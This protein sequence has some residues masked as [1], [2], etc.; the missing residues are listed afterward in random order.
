[1]ARLEGGSRRAERIDVR[2]RGSHIDRLVQTREMVKN[3]RH[4][5]ETRGSRKGSKSLRI[6]QQCSVERRALAAGLQGADSASEMIA[7]VRHPTLHT[8][9]RPAALADLDALVALEYRV[10]TCDRISRRSFRRFLA[11]PSAA[12]IAA[13]DHGGLAG[14]A[15]VL[16]RAGSPVARLY[17]IAVATE[18]AGRGIGSALLAA[19]EDAAQRHGA[20]AMRL[21]VNEH[22]AAAISRYRKAD[23]RLFARRTAY[24]EDGATALRYEKRLSQKSTGDEDTSSPSS[25]RA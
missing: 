16:F 13:G 5:S 3:R 6:F 10:F 1:M 14:Y 15:L 23:Y 24:Y 22:N 4:K 12:L 21:E 9:T 11:A 2:G 25:L 20:L 7:S 19:A 17:S 8:E 18:R